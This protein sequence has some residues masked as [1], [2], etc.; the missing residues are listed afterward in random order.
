LWAP[1][2]DQVDPKFLS[3]SAE[4]GRSPDFLSFRRGLEDTVVI[5]VERQRSPVFS[6]PSTQ[7]IEVCLYRLTLVESRH[8]AIG[9][10]VD[11]R[12]EN[13]LFS[14]TF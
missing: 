12:N 11:H 3:S 5:G 4:L 9:G 14:S 10:V 8:E 6:Q 2:Q 7:Q 13:H 1:S